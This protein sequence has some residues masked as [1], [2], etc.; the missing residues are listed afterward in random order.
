MKSVMMV[1]MYLM[2]DAIIVS[3]PVQKIVIIAS[4]EFVTIVYKDLSLNFQNV[5]LIVEM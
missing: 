2:M 5:F 4:K 1:M 3:I